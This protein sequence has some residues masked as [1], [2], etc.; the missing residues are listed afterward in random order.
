MNTISGLMECP[1]KA[2]G[3]GAGAGT[4]ADEAGPMRLAP[5]SG[6]V[7]GT[8]ARNDEKV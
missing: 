7:A 5:A 8:E 6:S 2:A 3:A 1:T 4:A